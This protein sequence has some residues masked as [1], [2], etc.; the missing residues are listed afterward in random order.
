VKI[1]IVHLRYFFICGNNCGRKEEGEYVPG[2]NLGTIASQKG[3]RHIEKI[4]K[5]V[6]PECEKHFEPEYKLLV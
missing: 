6:C 5:L 1:G 3:W 4:D 2:M